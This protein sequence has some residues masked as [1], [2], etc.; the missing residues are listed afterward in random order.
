VRLRKDSITTSSIVAV[1]PYNTLVT[2]EEKTE[3]DG[4]V[5]GKTEYDGKSGWCV[6]DY[7]EHVSGSIDTTV[8]PD[9]NGYRRWRIVSDDGVKL[10]Y[11]YGT[12]HEVL[13]VVPYGAVITVY[14]EQNRDGYTW[15]RTE[16]DG[17]TGWCVLNYATVVDDSEETLEGIR[18]V[19]LPDK[20]KY[21]AGELFDS[22][23]MTVAALYS[24]G[25]EELVSEYGCSGNTMMPG[26]STITVRYRD[27]GFE[28]SVLVE[29]RAGDINRNG[30]IDSYDS[31]SLKNHILCGDGEG[32]NSKLADV[33]S[34]SVLNVFDSIRIKKEIVNNS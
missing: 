14:E 3:R 23:G 19:S 4:F 1:I 31:L 26:V 2:I 28:I 17:K 7:A 5:W 11:N 15:G 9:G 29:A 18:V 27:K 6:L 21:T 12:S 22:T 16:Y 32:F 33:N 8:V 30:T 20:L 34:D 13:G 10:R 25:R 24:T